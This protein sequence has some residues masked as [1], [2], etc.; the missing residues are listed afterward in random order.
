[1]KK[2]GGGEVTRTTDSNFYWNGEGR[3]FPAYRTII[4]AQ[5][6]HVRSVNFF[7]AYIFLFSISFILMQIISF[8]RF[9]YFS[10]SPAYV[11][12]WHIK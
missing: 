2:I 5:V 8:S 11:Y 3:K 10:N 4:L 12:D 7:L 9:S 6:D 1:M